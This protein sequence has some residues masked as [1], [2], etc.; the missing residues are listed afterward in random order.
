MDGDPA[1]EKQKADGDSID[2]I[3]SVH[4]P[5]LRLL[6][7]PRSPISDA[8][9]REST[10]S[11]SDTC[12]VLRGCVSVLKWAVENGYPIATTSS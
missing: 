3:K 1:F 7:S 10:D 12:W 2:Q 11:V 4:V 5:R 6:F 9:R 8:R